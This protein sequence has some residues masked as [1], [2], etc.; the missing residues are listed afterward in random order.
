[1]VKMVTIHPGL[2][3]ETVKKYGFESSQL[4]RKKIAEYLGWEHLYI[5]THPQIRPDW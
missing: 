4:S 1:M 2:W 3:K 5:L